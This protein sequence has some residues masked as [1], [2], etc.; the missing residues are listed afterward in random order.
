MEP[1]IYNSKNLIDRALS[2]RDAILVK[3]N[4]CAEKDGQTY[5]SEAK[6]VFEKMQNPMLLDPKADREEV[7]QC[8][9]DLFEQMESVQQK[10]KA[11]KDRQKELKVEVIKLDYLHE[12]QT[13]LKMR[14]VMGTCIDQWDNIVQRWTEVPF[15]NLEPEEVTSTTMK[16][17]KTVQMLEKGL[18]PNDVVSMLKKKVEVM[19]QRLQV[20]T[21]MRNPHLKK[22]HWDLIQ[23]ALNYKFIKDEPLTLGLLIEIDA[24]DKSEEMMEIAGMASSQAALEAI[25]KKVV[26][27]WKHVEFPVLPYKD[28]K[29]V[30]II[31]ST[32]EIQQLLDDSNINIQTIQSSRHV[33][34]IKTKVEEWAASLSLFNKT[35]ES[36]INCQ[37]TW[38]YL[39]SIFSAPDIQRQLPVE[40]KLFVE[41]D[42]SYKEIMRRVKKTPLAIRNGTQPG[43]WETFEYN[44]ELLDKILKCLEAYLETKRV[45]F[46]RF[47][48]LSNDELLEILAQTRNPL[49]VQPHLRKCFDAIH[50]LEFAVV[51]GLPPE[52][53]I[54]FTN[55][56]LSMISPE[57]EKIGLGKGL[58]ARGNVEDW[59]GKVEE[60]MFASIRRLCKKSI[61]D[62]ETMSFLSWIMSNASQVVLTICQMMWT[63]DVTA[64]LR[65]SRTVIRG[66]RDFE[67]RSFTELN[68]LAGAVRGELPKLAR[69]T[70]C[71]LI[72]I[73]VHARDIISEMVKKQVSELLS[74]DWQKQLRYYWNM[75]V[76][77]CV[78]CMSIAVYTY[79][80]EYLGACPRLVITPLTDRCYLCLMGA[81]QLDLGGAP[82]GPAGT[83]KTETT[84]DLAKALAIWCVVF[85]CSD[86]LDYK[87]MGGFFSGLAQSGAWC[88][89]DEFNR[90]NIEVLSVI[91]QQLITIRNAKV[92]KLNR[93]MF[94]GREIK[95]VHTC[96]AFITMN[97]G[98]AGRTEL[99]DNLQALFRPI[100]MM[101]PD[102]GLIAEVILYSEG[103]ESSR[104][105]AKKMVQMYKL[106][107]EQL[108][109]QDHYDFGMRAVKSVLVMAGSLK[110][111][112]PDKPE[113]VVLIRALR[114]SNLPKFLFN[115]AKLFQAILSDLFPG[116]NIPEHDYGQLK[117]EIMNIQ[118]EM[119]LQVVDTQVVKVI[120][121]LETMIVRHGVMLV[122]PT[123][124]G[125]T[126][127][128]RILEKALTSLYNQGVQNEFY[129]PVHVYVMN[130]KSITM[131]E[132]YGGVDK[133]T[134][135][136]KDGLMGL[137]VRF[138]VNDTTK[139][140]QW[141][142]C[143]GPVDALWIENMNT[144]LD[145]NKMLCLANSER[146]KFTPY[147][148]M[149]FEVQD[150]AVASPATVSRCG[151]VYVDPDELKWLPFVKT[152]LDK[153]G[154]NMSPE[155]PAYL[156]KL[157]EIYVEDGLRFVSKKCTQTMNQVDISKINSFC[158]LLEAIFF[159]K[160]G[161]FDWSL[162][163]SKMF[164]FLC[165]IFVFCYLWALGGN[166]NDEYRDAF[167]L[168]IRQQF[169]ENQDAK[170]PGTYPLWSYY[171]E[172]DS[173]RMDLWE[174]LVSSFRFDKSISFFKMMVPTVDTARYG[175]FL[176]RLLSVQKPVLFTGG[177]GVGKSV[178]VRDLLDRIS[179]RMNY[180][181]VY[182]N[183]SAQTS[184]GRTQEIIEGKLEKRKKNVIGAPQGKRVVIFIDDLNM[185]KLDTYGSQPPIELLRQYLDFDGLYDRETM[186][187]KE[188]QDVTLAAACSPPGGG[189][190]PVSPRLF[191]HFSMFTIP[192]PTEMSLKQMFLA[193]IN[194]FLLDFSRNARTLAEPIVNSAVELYFRMSSDL[195]PTPAKSHYVFN[196][197]D[198]SKVVQGILQAD[199]GIF[200]EKIQI[201]RLFIHETQRVFHDRLINNEDKLFFHKLMAEIVYKTFNENFDPHSFIK[202]PLL[203]GNF[204]KMGCPPEEK[205]YEEISDM[206]KLQ[207]VL[208]EYLDDLNLTSPKEMRL[209]FF[210]DAMEHITRLVRM[211]QQERGN[212]LL[213]G[214]GGTGKQSL[215]RLSAHMCNYRC[216][217]IE[218]FRGYDYSSFHDDLK[219]LYDTA[220]IQNKPSIFLFTDT[221]IVVEEFLEDINNMLNSGEVP[222]LFEPDEY[223]RLIIGCRPGAKEA[224]IPEGNRDAIYD[225]CIHCVRNNLHIVLCMSPVGSAFR[226]RCRMFPSLVNCCTIDWFIEWP[227]E[228]LLGVAQSFFK[229]VSLGC[230][231]EIKVQKQVAIDEAK[232]KTTAEETQA[233]ADDAQRDLNEALPALEVAEKALLALDKN[234]IAE[235]RVFTKPPEL[236]QT[237]LE[238]VAILLGNKTDWASCKAMLADTNFLKKIYEYDKENVP[239]AKLAKVR[240]Y[241]SMPSFVP[242]VVAKVSKACKT[243][244]L[245]VR[246]IDVYSAVAKQVEP[247]KQALA[248]AQDVLNEVLSVLKAKQ[249]QLA[250]VEKQ[251]KNLQA[252]FDKS[253]AE[254]KSL[255]RNMAV[256]AARLKRSSKL[257]TALADEQV[258]W[259]E[260]VA[261]FDVQL[262]NVVGDVFIAAACVAYYGAFTSTY[263]QKLVEGWTKRL[264][265]L[266][267]PATENMTLVSVLADI[268]EIRQWNADGLPRDAVSIENA[269]LV[270]KGRRWPL[271]IDPQEQANR[272]IRNREAL[273][274]L[275]IIKLSNSNFLRT[276]EACIRAGLPV[277][278][279]DV[280][281]ALDPALEPVLLK[282]TFIQGGRVLI[283]L[284]DSDIDYDRNFRFYMTTKLS[285]PH[286]LPE[287]CIKVTV[288][289][290]TVTKK[291]LEDQ[292]LSDVVSL[293]RPDLEEQRNELI[294]RINA[295][296]N[297]LKSI[298]DKILKLL[299]ESEGN[300]LDNEELINTLNDSK[301]TSAVIKQR[302]AESETT[303]EKISVAR[304]KYRCVAERGSVMY[305]V[306]SDMGEVDPMY[307]FSLKY[308]KQLFNNTISTS[309]KSDD[310]QTR[311]D[312][313]LEETTVCIYKN[314][315]R[316]LFE[317]HKLVFSFLLCS[318]I[319]KT[320][321][322]ITPLEWNFFLRGPIGG[323]EKQNVPKPENTTWLPLNVWKMACEMSDTFE[324]FRYIHYDLDKTPVW[325]RLDEG[326]EV[327]ANPPPERYLYAVLD[328]PEYNDGDLP[329]P[330]RVNGNWNDRLTAFQKLMFVKVFRE[331]R[332]TF[333][334][335]EFV[336]EC[337]GKQ[338]VESPPVTLP[339]LYESMSKTTPLVFVLSPGSD[340][341]TSFLRFA[342]DMGVHENVKSI[343]L[344]QGQGPV[345]DK[346][347]KNATKFGEW[348]FLQNC[349]L[350]ASWMNAM[351]D[352][353]KNIQETSSLL[354]SNFRLYLSSMPAKHFPV[355]VLQNS[356]KVT[357]EPPKGIR[358]NLRRAFIDMSTSFF[359]D[360]PLGMDWRKIIFGIC[361]FHAVILERK[362]FGPL[363]WNITYA[364][365]DSDRECALLNM[366]MFCKDGYIPWETLIYITGE[367]TYGGR[368]T[369]AQDQ[370]CLRTIL[371]FF[372]RPETLKPKYKY[373]ESG[374][375]YPP[376]V[377]TLATV[378]AYIESLPLIDEPEIFGLHENAN[379]AFQLNETNALLATI[380]D[381]QPRIVAADGGMSNDDITYELA[382]AV[383][384]R[385]IDKLDIERANP[386][387]FTPDAKGRI[388]SLTI[389][390]MQET[391]RFNKLL[392][393]IKTSLEQLKKAI[394]GFVVMSEE[395][396]NVYNA[397]LNNHV[398][399]L[400]ARNAYPSLKSLASWVK[401]L[402][403]RCCF[404]DSWINN[405]P[406]KS[407]W[408]SGFFFPQGFLTG[409]LQNFA[410]KYNQPIDHLSFKFILLPYS[411]EE[412]LVMEQLRT[413][414]KGETI[415]MDQNL[416]VPDDGVLVHG[417]YM[418]GFAWDWDHM[419]VGDQLKGQMQANLPVMHMDPRLDYEPDLSLYPA[420]LYKTAA[421][422]GTLSTTGHSTNFVVTVHL[423]SSNTQD[424]WIAKGAAL[425]CQISD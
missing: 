386:N 405:G 136:W 34:P 176:E 182:I 83:G 217:Q 321:G 145:D 80:Y 19:K 212:A 244:V 120:Q 374:I 331:E 390:L 58:K 269:V 274:K 28:Q 31:G 380:L 420:P 108:S 76:D 184:S 311:L 330:D 235:I 250:E 384:D 260:S 99:P 309:E 229:T 44:N 419:T 27:A 307:Q 231:D 366:E 289:N 9:N 162:E 337:L 40:A 412:A 251:I 392:I 52:E 279:E 339:E 113:D 109:Q 378:K 224:G 387:M 214:V 101:V 358:A 144:V 93:F 317:K 413:V 110:R 329:L 357:N 247:K 326:P 15:M 418:D 285:N 194:G 215:T 100:S 197:R 207:H 2:G 127:I 394:K 8:L 70:L 199:A 164:R 98:Y 341:M 316:G 69:A 177:T 20:I 287:V 54:Q 415:P 205:F 273:N 204:M 16:Y 208:G 59:L 32:D 119:K 409:T 147:I 278:M 160:L 388:N 172:V 421:R 304:E 237:V 320:E 154:K 303:E 165:Q 195:L 102:Y 243:L 354:H 275:K 216:F 94:E 75:E 227:K 81:L 78:V 84:K 352:I 24:F 265:D 118:L 129:Q 18:P 188:I 166:L 403:M 151:M 226:S 14:D 395:L 121:F 379:I 407:F 349:H 310:L 107:S 65:D 67:Q 336:S 175:Y 335:T 114:D 245:W 325:I 359:E 425:L 286:Y 301:V 328:P 270:T 179:E 123:G 97:P 236:V 223:E 377:K 400:W 138:C 192:S 187:W 17:L 332:T 276:L 296:K 133:Q 85:N 112:N 302:L 346:M 410:R 266:Q 74:F 163:S 365:S 43:L 288:I 344:G 318:E 139:D 82:A 130:P 56:I 211:I 167:D 264:I 174:R 258:R 46:P 186:T 71:A 254:K 51:E 267:I 191:R 77:N 284:G 117:D 402:I 103:F 62:Y 61:K 36:W 125:K 39:E 63:R 178:I 50:R 240:K 416:D 319:M 148:H 385:L 225:Y 355:S 261:N 33:G 308:F 271:M 158:K 200:R 327:R 86:S 141:I 131:N 13:E 324:D 351:E 401:D 404:I 149:I 291:G 299:F 362:K 398:P 132:L 196:L 376:L 363:G 232:A 11:L 92:A 399:E 383:L 381:V 253:M 295:D 252:V 30:Y 257:T 272:W 268:Y 183:F 126:T 371:K 350:A 206:N 221:Q 422:A 411:R 55:D 414:K 277:L 323:I 171:I 156:L 48:F 294:M 57:G 340:P 218:L 41:V 347:I 153:W 281:E 345:A 424:Y 233:I 116:V 105:L 173:K 300:I 66:M 106:C 367:I 7:R 248:E 23:E 348:V 259:E 370:R 180:V 143:D 263:R 293:E 140:H 104:T 22:R 314:V 72:T 157:F 292:L 210:M 369:D 423:P 96:A 219:K 342:K 189:R 298:E 256:T 315:S 21:D 185:P 159:Y 4:K 230:S 305:F 356:V 53:E 306:V 169:D 241:T 313:C 198:L 322:E 334:V 1:I 155:A 262:K 361:F 26:D 42:R 35:L 135:E 213:V 228:A 283:R 38:L 375:Y 168:F 170:L 408:L 282:Q 203:F 6:N 146:I 90:I 297:Q 161:Q 382:E 128:Y 201:V 239:A 68:L 142:V 95:L 397:F 60:A 391:E 91:A 222:N 364:F 25:L 353:I 5:L 73:N 37:R 202:D 10:S 137:T 115:D 150:L 360:H 3:F 234:D 333:A 343:S 406:P 338:F 29:D 249:D 389:V 368:V 417:L 64:I 209:V 312:I 124:G 280:G 255:E 190:N 88:C 238:A 373:S 242:D 152:W 220:G 45:T 87:M 79:G 393:I 49:A 290:F 372:F 47:Y 396:E 246:A 193:I 111:Q 12:V 134:L 89:F 181:P 122:G